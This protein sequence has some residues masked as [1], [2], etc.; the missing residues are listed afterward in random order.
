M[1]HTLL[2]AFTAVSLVSCSG[3]RDQQTDL[4]TFPLRGKVVE[5]DTAQGVLTVAHEAIPNYMNAMT[6]PFKVKERSQLLAIG[7]GDTIHA[8]LAVSRT[9]SW[10]EG[11]TVAGRGVPEKTLSAD[12]IFTAKVF[13]TS[14]LFPD[15]TLLNQDG[16][17]IR[18]STFRGKVVALTFI[19][20]RC[21]LPD[22][23]I[24]MSDHFA[25][26]QKS[27][28]RDS[29]L[30]GRWHLISISFDPRFD[31]P[32]VLKRYAGSYGADFSTWDFVTDP[33]TAG[34]AIRRLADGLGLTYADD[35]GLIAHNLRTVLLDK[36]GRLVRVINGNEWKAEEVAAE[37]RALAAR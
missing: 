13:R 22:F 6:M 23:C 5:I 31:R 1:R 35:E 18:L 12:E 16:A 25:R 32:A 15:E 19:Y 24:R 14:E 34:S 17:P 11:I 7:A 26:I 2:I 30:G 9:E 10:L 20:T 8:T 3:K 28:S 29:D 36:E 37:I 21:P 4:V 33:D 27:L